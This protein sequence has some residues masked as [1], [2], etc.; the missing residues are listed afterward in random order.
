MID[1]ALVPYLFDTSAQSWLQRTT[2][3]AVRSWLAT[4]LERHPL[5]VSAITVL[6]RVR[7]YALL[8]QQAAP[9]RQGHIA[10]K[11]QVYLDSPA[12]VWPVDSGVALL[13]GELAA[14][15][16]QPPAPLKRSHRIAESRQDWLFRWRCDILIAATALA[17]AMPLIHHNP[18]DFETIRMAIETSPARFPTLGPLN[19]V[20]VLRLT[21]P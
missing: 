21:Q 1:P 5:C 16:P 13:A 20:S 9:E 2:D 3:A 17:A 8:L 6:E 19:L 18:R 4:Y 12:K 15:L 11:R 14:L 10:M 7:G